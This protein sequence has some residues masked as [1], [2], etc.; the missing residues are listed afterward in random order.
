MDSVEFKWL[1]S[2]FGLIFVISVAGT[3]I[4]KLITSCN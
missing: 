3:L 2:F 4:E 1:I